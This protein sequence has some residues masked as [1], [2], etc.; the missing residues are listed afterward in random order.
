MPNQR[1]PREENDRRAY[2]RD[3]GKCTICARRGG[4][5]MV[6]VKSTTEMGTYTL[7]MIFEDA[8][9]SFAMLNVFF[10]YD[11]QVANLIAVIGHEVFE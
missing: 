5:A 1:T 3:C 8:S 2:G 6:G 4:S 7:N 10:R 9:Y 11:R